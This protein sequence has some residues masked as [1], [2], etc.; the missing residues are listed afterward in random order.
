MREE[1]TKFAEKLSSLFS[2]II[3]RTLTVQ[4]L[5]ELEELDITLPQLQALTHVGER[6]KCS[7]GE[8]ADGLSVTHPA[9]VKMVDRLV[10]KGMLTRSISSSDHRQAEIQITAGGRELVNTVRRERTERLSRVLEQMPA[11]E[12]A[13]MIQGL[14]RFV[15]IALRN[16]GAL[17]AICCSCQTL[18]PTD[19][20]DWEGLVPGAQRPVPGSRSDFATLVT[21]SSRERS[22]AHLEP[23]TGHRAPGTG[24]ERP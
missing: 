24:A 17:D 19:C 18:L 2:E 15:T 7:I 22:D 23:G 4:L 20:K 1:C 3:F 13:A 16:E 8:I 14:E 10:K 11:D 6:Q 5:R 9:A 12:R 21:I